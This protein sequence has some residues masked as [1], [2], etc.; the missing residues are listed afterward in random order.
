MSNVFTG[1]GRKVVAILVILAMI[2]LMA[3]CSREK[4]SDPNG[5]NDGQGN[6]VTD[7]AADS[8]NSGSTGGDS[9]GEASEG[10]GDGSA[11]QAALKVISFEDKTTQGFSGRGGSEVL[12]VTDEANVT[13]GGQYSLKVTGRTETWHGP[14]LRIEEY[15]EEGAEYK[16]AVRVKLIEP[17]SAQ[18]ML[19]TQIGN[20][21]DANYVNIAQHVLGTSDGWV[22]LEGSY[23][24]SAK[25]DYITIY[26]ESANANASF[27]IDDIS[28]AK[29]GKIIEGIQTELPGIKEVYK[30]YFLIG[31]AIALEDT[32]GKRL[33]LLKKHHNVATAGNAMKPDALQP[34][35]G[36]FNF[37]TADKM[38]DKMLAEGLKMHGHTL[39]W[40][41]QSPQWMNQSAKDVYLNRE[42]AL[43][44]LRT[45]IKT[46]VEHFGDKVISWDV[47]NEA[48][49]DNPSNPENWKAALRKSPWYHAIGDD[50][51]E[52]AFLAAREVLDEHPE[53]DI[54]LY[55]ND[56][57]LDNQNKSKAVY[58]MVRELNEKYQKDHPGKLLIDGVGMQAHYTVNTNPNNVKLSLER[59]ISLG[60]E[61][62]ITELDIQAGNNY[63]L[64]EKEAAQQGYLYAQLFE[65][66]REHADNI[67]RVTFWGMDD[68][69]SWRA[70]TNPT[71]FDKYLQAKPAFYGVIDPEKFMKEN[72]LEYMEANTSVARYGTP[73]IDGVADSVWSKAPALQINRYQ[74]AWQ[75]AN[76]T[77]RVLWDEENL[78]VMFYVND[79]QLDKANAN[80]WEQDSVEAFVDENN[81]KTSFYQD[82]DGQYRV[83][84]ENTATFNPE[85]IAKGF[86]SAVKV[87]GTGY[88]VEMKIPF[89]TI[90]PEVNMQI[91]FDAQIYDAKSGSRQSVATWNDITGN[92]YQDTSVYGVLTLKK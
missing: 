13:E 16:F 6:T 52:Q 20:G 25:N 65:I 14:S 8:G 91:G 23:R 45:H 31:N 49:S 37:S 28:I 90:T 64:S 22:T 82:D 46:V 34:Q 35:K 70:P 66:F 77:A 89:R 33:E 62:S 59:F 55:Y 26:V 44:N 60:V 79:Q 39:V 42:E 27:Y 47:V 41:Q 30:D 87:S 50:Y 43:E 53:W 81:E 1:N 5:A 56:Y 69:T 58:S 7:G 67:A 15:V 73:V 11:G 4:E 92:G 19:S 3:A 63:K 54:K 21:S 2:V 36:K 9:Q 86:E 61:V 80:P 17:L 68:G 38:V 24:Y 83:N 40:H 57:N 10:S 76:G 51:V 29:T 32:Y 72:N 48:M 71:L 75:G 88:T 78:Y 84:Y 18:I 74:T 12:T 85:N